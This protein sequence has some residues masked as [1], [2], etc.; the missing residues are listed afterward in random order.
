MWMPWLPI[1]SPAPGSL[2]TVDCTVLH[3][4]VPGARR[5]NSEW[6]E[7]G[8]SLDTPAAVASR[9][10]GAAADELESGDKKL[11]PRRLH[12]TLVGQPCCWWRLRGTG[13]AI[14]RS[15]V[16]NADSAAVYAAAR[17]SGMS[18]LYPWPQTSQMCNQFCLFF[19][20][21]M[22][23]K[24]KINSTISKSNSKGI[25]LEMWGAPG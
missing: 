13:R 23:K 24:W 5:R 2:V 16:R 25:Q 3:H 19:W 4:P 9:A 11:N 1:S 22:N 17:C 20:G 6:K 15:A 12:A 10:I 8:E 18:E 7:G 21:T 14:Q